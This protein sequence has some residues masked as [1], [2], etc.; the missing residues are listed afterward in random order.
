MQLFIRGQRSSPTLTEAGVLLQAEAT[1]L[2]SHAYRVELTLDE[3]RVGAKVLNVGSISSALS[4]FVPAAVRQLKRSSPQIS[5]VVE[6]S[7]EAYIGGSLARG[8]I[9]LGVSRRTSEDAGLRSAVIAS[10]RLLV[11]V[12]EDSELA[13]TAGLRLSEL[14]EKSFVSFL[15]SDAPVAYDRMVAYCMRA[16]FSPAITYNA[17]ND[18]SLMSI[19]ACGM[20]IALVPF[21]TSLAPFPGVRYVPV[22]EEWAVAP[23]AFVARSGEPTPGEAEFVETAANVLSG[24]ADESRCGGE[25]LLRLEC[26]D[27]G[28]TGAKWSS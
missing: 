19:V 12:P 5:V 20:A 21:M 10:E 22:K 3:A 7:E 8:Q 23:L 17:P 1:A 26:E 2:L 14:S 13:C 18:H 11:A 25:W 4:G 24:I 16:G 27:V 28:W 9:D 15:R 6:E